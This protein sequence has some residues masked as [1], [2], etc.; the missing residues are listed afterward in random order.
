MDQLPKT[1]T[2]SDGH[3][4]AIHRAVQQRMRLHKLLGHSV[5]VWQDGKIVVIPPEEI[6]FDE[7]VANG[8]IRLPLD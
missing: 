7:E 8:P 2:D 5:V 6:E 3:A 4:K 1:F